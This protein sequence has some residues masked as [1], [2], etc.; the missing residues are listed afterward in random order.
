M[1]LPYKKKHT[2]TIT[3]SKGNVHPEPLNGLVNTVARFE[4]ARLNRNQPLVDRVCMEHIDNNAYDITACPQSHYDMWDCFSFSY[5]SYGRQTG[6]QRATE[7]VLTQE[8]YSGLLNNK[9]NRYRVDLSCTA[10]RAWPPFPYLTEEEIQQRADT[11][12]S[13]S[14][15]GYQ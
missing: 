12:F 7:R 3:D 4:V 14:S 13:S 15:Q 6:D 9:C 8:A 10:P 1:I 11:F 2:T 5:C